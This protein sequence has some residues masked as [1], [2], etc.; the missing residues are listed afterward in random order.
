MLWLNIVGGLNV[1]PKTVRTHGLLKRYLYLSVR[2]RT[3]PLSPRG[4]KRDTEYV[5]V[6]FGSNPEFPQTNNVTRMQSKFQ[7]TYAYGE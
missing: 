7:E 4:N 6:N 5:V 1:I 2:P 3:I